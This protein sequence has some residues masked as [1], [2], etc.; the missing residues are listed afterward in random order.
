MGSGI[1]RIARPK[2]SRA[3]M[4][5]DGEIPRPPFGQAASATRRMTMEELTTA[6]VRELKG[7][8]SDAGIDI[9]DCIERADLVRGMPL[10]WL[11]LQLGTQIL[12]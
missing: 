5:E 8:L 7:L 6:S 3:T 11:I 9:R 2:P 12:R 10:G 4:A 1:S